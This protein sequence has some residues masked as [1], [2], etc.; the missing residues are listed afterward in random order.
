VVI[1]S[2][3]VGSEIDIHENRFYRIFPDV[4]NFLNAQISRLKLQPEGYFPYNKKKYKIKITIKSLSGKKNTIKR[5]ISQKEFNEMRNHINKQE[6]FTEK[7]K[8]EMYEGMD[9]LRSEKIVSSIPKPQFVK[10]K[11]SNKRGV[12]KGTLIM[13]ENNFL[14]IQTPTMIEKISLSDLDFLSYRDT[15]KI[16]PRLR[17]YTYGFNS[18]VG[19]LSARRFNDQRELLYNENNIPRK[20]IFAYTQIMGIVIG[21]IFSSEVFD[22][23][24]TLLTPTKSIILSKSAYEEKNYK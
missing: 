12:L 15:I 17:L 21:L 6:V 10:L 13:F 3:K 9:Y 20:D 18:F 24:S 14:H 16:Y 8:I 2:E 5:I 22:A 23:M 1:L 7:R 4:E 11:H 19:L